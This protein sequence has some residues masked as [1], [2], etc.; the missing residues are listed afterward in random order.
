MPQYPKLPQPESR[1]EHT[2][3]TTW[4]N[5]A[6]DLSRVSDP[7]PYLQIFADRVRVGVL[8][9]NSS[10][11]KKRTVEGYPRDMTHIFAGVWD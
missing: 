3:F 1:A 11:V 4:L 2:D 5:I 8:S 9:A 6:P 7:I 10:G